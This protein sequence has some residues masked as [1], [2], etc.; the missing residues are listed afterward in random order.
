MAGRSN[1][2]QR[3]P[4]RCLEH[5]RYSLDS[6][7]GS[8][9]RS[10]IGPREYPRIRVQHSAPRSLDLLDALEVIGGMNALDLIRSRLAHRAILARCEIMRA[11]EMPQNRLQT[12]GPLRMPGRNPVVNH[13]AICK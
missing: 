1:E 11:F 6:C 2:T 7:T 10:P 3:S 13:P 12:L 5:E 9:P 8:Q 4:F